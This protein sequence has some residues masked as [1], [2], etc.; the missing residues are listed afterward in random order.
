VCLNDATQAPERVGG[1][2]HTIVGG[3]V[4]D[5]K[6]LLDDVRRIVAEEKQRRQALS[7]AAA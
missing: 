7:P 5:A 1:V 6:A 3:A 2:R 4:H